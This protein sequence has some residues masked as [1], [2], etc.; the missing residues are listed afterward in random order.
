MYCF[1]VDIPRRWIDSI[2]LPYSG[3]S[4]RFI[5]GTNSQLVSLTERFFTPQLPDIAFRSALFGRPPII[6]LRDCDVPE[7]L[8]VD[9][10]FI[11]KDKILEQPASHQT[12]LS[13]FVAVIRLHVVLEVSTKSQLRWPR[14][15]A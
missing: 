13:A 4:G 8:Q 6:H 3:L 12:R 14:L 15:I 7:P 2:T 9:D 1:P 10:E 11:T 5:V